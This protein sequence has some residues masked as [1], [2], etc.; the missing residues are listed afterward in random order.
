M[1]VPGINNTP[2]YS[3]FQLTDIFPTKN[4][5]SLESFFLSVGACAMIKLDILRRGE[6]RCNISEHL[7]GHFY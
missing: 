1:L 2:S 6:I 3:Q 4:H 7:Y 5:H